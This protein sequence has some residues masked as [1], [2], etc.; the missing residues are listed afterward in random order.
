MV[1]QHKPTDERRAMV[2]TMSAGGT[3][4]EDIAKVLGIDAKTLRK[5]YRE[6]LD[7][8]AIKANAAVAQSLFKK[9]TGDG[10]G[11]VTAA[12]FWMKT[13]AGWQDKQLHEHTGQISVTI[14]PEDERL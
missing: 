5:H 13:R 9:A 4:Q 12:I 8:A 7:L 14:A 6:E 11:A 3:P 2:R 10:K 1:K